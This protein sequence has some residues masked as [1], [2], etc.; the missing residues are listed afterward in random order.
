MQRF[1]LDKGTAYAVVF[2]EAHRHNDVPELFFTG[3]LGTWDNSDNTDDHVTLTCRY[4]AIENQDDFA[5]TLMDVPETFDSPLRGKKLSRTEGLNHER[6]NEFWHVIDFLVE[7]D[8]AIHDFIYHP[9]K[10]SIKALFRIYN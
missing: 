6:I 1:V 5:C 10:N 9:R 4:G 8:I 2:V 7:N 3:I